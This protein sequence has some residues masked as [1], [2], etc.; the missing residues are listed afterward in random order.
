MIDVTLLRS[1]NR[2][3]ECVVYYSVFIVRY[4]TNQMKY[5]DSFRKLYSMLMNIDIKL[6]GLMHVYDIHF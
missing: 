1:Q 4:P 6:I 5:I 3:K 2:T